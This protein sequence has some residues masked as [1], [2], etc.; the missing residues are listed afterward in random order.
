MRQVLAQLLRIPVQGKPI[1]IIDISGVPSEIVDVV[2]SVL[3]EIRVADPA[4]IA[5]WRQQLEAYEKENGEPGDD[6]TET[7][8][9]ELRVVELRETRESAASR[10]MESPPTAKKSSWRRMPRRW[11]TSSQRP[12]RRSSRASTEA[13]CSW[14]SSHQNGCVSRHY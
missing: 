13:G 4:D 8:D 11:R 14:R 1:T 5:R 6:D 2:V 10:M 9:S 7:E 12:I 3:F